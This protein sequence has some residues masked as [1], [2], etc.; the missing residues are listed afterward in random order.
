MKK[1]DLLV[2]AQDLSVMLGGSVILDKISVNVRAGEIVSIIGPNGSGK[3][4]L[5]KALLGLIKTDSGTVVRREKLRVGYV[6]QR[7][8]I[9]ESLPMT[10]A[11]FVTLGTK[12]GKRHVAET[13]DKLQIHFLAN[14]PLQKVSGGE[15]QR[16]L[17]ARAILRKPELLVLDEP[18]QGVDVT[19]QEELYTL[20]KDIRD[21]LNCGVLIVS[22]DLHLVMAAT[23][24]VLCINHHLCCEGQPASVAEHPAYRELF[25]RAGTEAL[26]VYTHHHDHSHTPSGDVVTATEKAD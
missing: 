22:H 4:T 5:T 2:R 1:D 6:P 23:D 7:V 12:A 11:R 16:I 19:G 15:F 13:L 8:S 21:D 9:D 24:H 18:A 20:I 14:R 10:V 25:G 26:A 3:T 17:L